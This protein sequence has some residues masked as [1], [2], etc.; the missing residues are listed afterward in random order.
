[1]NLYEPKIGECQFP[2]GTKEALA[3]LFKNNINK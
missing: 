2:D 1:M 3:E